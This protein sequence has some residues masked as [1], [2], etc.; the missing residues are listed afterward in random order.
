MEP[1]EP[2]P[3]IFTLREESG[4]SGK[5]RQARA[6]VDAGLGSIA[7]NDAKEAEAA[8]KRALE[9]D[10]T[11]TQARAAL[12]N[13][14]LAIGYKTEGERELLRATQ[15]DSE[16]EALL[17]SYAV[18]LGPATSAEIEKI[19]RA[20]L[21]ER[22][23]S[24]VAKKRLA[25]IYILKDD[26]EKGWKITHE[27]AK[28]SRGDAD[29]TYFYGRLHLA[30]REYARA[31]EVLSSA[32]REA[33]GFAPAHYFLGF[34]QLGAK[35]VRLAMTA[36]LRVKELNPLWLAPRI[37]LARSYMIVGDYDRALEELAPVVQAQPR[38]FDAL[39]VEGTSRLGK[40]QTAHALEL[41]QKAKD[42]A[43]DNA[44]PYVQMGAVY[45]EQQHYPQALTA[46]EEALTRDPDRIE[47]LASVAKILALKGNQRAGFARVEQQLDKTEDSRAEIYELLGRLSLDRQDYEKALNYLNKAEELKPDLLS[48]SLLIADIYMRQGK[49][50][51]AITQAEKI[52]GKHPKDHQPYMLLARLHDQ[53][54]EYEQANRYYR[55]VLALDTDSAAAAN[56][57]AWNYAEHGGRLDVALTLAQKARQLN[58]ND[59]RI[60]HTLGWIFYKSGAYQTAIRLLK[61]SS[62]ALKDRDP[63]VLYHLGLAYRKSGDHVLA[64]EALSK[65]LRLGR[66][67]TE[68]E[69]IKEALAKIVS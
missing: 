69:A 29:A 57:L 31:A 22:P 17:R 67:S 5:V 43:P 26:L 65:A 61:E 54:Q 46:Y 24:L 51:L 8:F 68:A 18:E 34:A 11:Y 39:M 63:T 48:A 30:H 41:F 59:P 13:L 9:I 52:I 6:Q 62:E 40:K 16:N 49:F 2:R 47:A 33:P 20:V 25:E 1:V 3:E 21:E 19:Y 36:F 42:L 50:D 7:R 15:M 37:A 45:L 64:K 23:G 66:D 35:H 14:Y 58:P 28:A 4:A 60:A 32:T 12:A 53:K 27:I 10:P 44:D 55:K 38:N 56:N